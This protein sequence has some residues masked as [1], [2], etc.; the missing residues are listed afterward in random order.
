MSQPPAMTPAVRQ[1]LVRQLIEQDPTLSSRAIADQ[2]GVG[3]DTVLRDLRAIRQADS[4][5]VPEP[6]ATEPESAPEEPDDVPD[7]APPASPADDRLTVAYDDQ[8]R[9]GL[10]V[11][12]EA[13]HSQEDAVRLAVA[14]LA[15]AY[16]GAWKFG[17]YPHGVAPRVH[18]VDLYPYDPKAPR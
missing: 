2:I 11:L 9:A 14:V 12:A 1:A 10:A 3:K 4:Q 17:L 15:R 6:A 5:S 16:E 18:H 13:G 8:L 7:D